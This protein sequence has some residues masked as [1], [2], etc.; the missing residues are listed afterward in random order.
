MVERRE[1]RIGAIEM[2]RCEE[3]SVSPSP[4]NDVMVASVAVIWSQT[5]IS[6]FKIVGTEDWTITLVYELTE[7]ICAVWSVPMESRDR[8][9]VL[10][11]SSKRCGPGTH[12]KD[13]AT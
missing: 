13:E 5:P 9:Q 3:C 4:G 1:M 2:Q 11:G 8:T 12:G 7:M 10:L 6:T